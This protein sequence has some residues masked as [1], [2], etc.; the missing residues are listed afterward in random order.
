[1]NNTKK[2]AIAGACIAL[3]ILLPLLTFNSMEL[4]T[5]FSLMHLP[6]ILCGFI[7]GW[8]YGL[9]VGCIAPLL[10]L[11]IFTAPPWYIAV[12]MAFELAAYGLVCALLYKFFPKKNLYI[13]I[14]L[15]CAMIIGRFVYIAAAYIIEPIAIFAALQNIFINTWGGIAIQIVL[16]PLIII[17][18]KKSKLIPNE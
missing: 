2:I 12:P 13:Y 10:R 9:A 8:Q 14:S 16:V 11:L 3:C 5:F 17:A 15:I 1:M 4:G 7:C 6:V 18:L